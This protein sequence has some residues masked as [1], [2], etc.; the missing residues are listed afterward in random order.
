MLPSTEF[1]HSKRLKMK[2]LEFIEIREI[3]V[4]SSFS[5]TLFPNISNVV[6]PAR[7]K[8]K[9]ELERKNICIFLS[10]LKYH[11]SHKFYYRMGA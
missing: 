2:N 6:I 10:A 9:A 5:K 7:S 3:S 4:Y 11:H 8:I 1:V